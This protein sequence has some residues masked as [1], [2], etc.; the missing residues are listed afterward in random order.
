MS[1][2]HGT[3]ILAV[4]YN[5]RTAM[6]ADGQVTAGDIV[7]KSNVRKIKT[8]LDGAVLAGF[9]GS[10]ADA[11]A[12]L[13]FFEKRIKATKDMEK[14]AVALAKEWRMNKV[15]SRL[16]AELL[17]ADKDEIILLGSEG[18]VIAAEGSTLAIGSGGQYAL[19]ASRA[20]LRM[21][22]EHF[23]AI[24][25]ARNSLQIASE[26]CIYTNSNIIV[27]EVNV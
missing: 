11:T 15:Y 14:A 5:G 10:V 26:I 23:T 27:E 22:D 19:A 13:D 7:V 9:A 17:L 24:E 18:D 25:I 3:T 6:A 12:L 2:F 21:K 16:N 20:Y 1:E 4:R 8:F